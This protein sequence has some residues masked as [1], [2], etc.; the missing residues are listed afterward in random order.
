MAR[1]R[2]QRRVPLRENHRGPPL[3]QGEPCPSPIRR[4][5]MASGFTD[6]NAVP[7]NNS[8]K[9][10]SDHRRTHP[11]RLPEGVDGPACHV[12]GAQGTDRKRNIVA[13]WHARLLFLA[14]LELAQLELAIRSRIDPRCSRT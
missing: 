2:Q 4:R 12:G 5:R 11:A 14:Y 13:A 10:S 9:N 6:E 1:D 7:A 8:Q 3:L